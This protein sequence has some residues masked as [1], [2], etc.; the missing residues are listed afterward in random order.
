[1]LTGLSGQSAACRPDEAPLPTFGALLSAVESAQCSSRHLRETAIAQEQ[2]LQRLRDNLQRVAG[3]G[4]IPH[5]P[6][7]DKQQPTAPTSTL[8]AAACLNGSPLDSCCQPPVHRD[9]GEPALPQKELRDPGEP[10]LLQK[11]H[12]AARVALTELDSAPSASHFGK[13]PEDAAM[14]MAPGASMTSMEFLQSQAEDGSARPSM[15]SNGSAD[16]EDKS[17]QLSMLENLQAMQKVQSRVS[18]C[19]SISSVA[20]DAPTLRAAWTQKKG[21]YKQKQ[22]TLRRSWSTQSGVASVWGQYR[23]KDLANGKE[24]F[25][26]LRRCILMPAGPVKLSWDLLCFIVI[27]WDVVMLPLNAFESTAWQMMFFVSV[28]TAVFWT[29]DM[30][31]SFCS[32]FHREDGMVETDPRQ[33]AWRYLRTWF[34]LDVCVLTLDWLLVF[35]DNA[36]DE[37]TSAGRVNKFVRVFRITKALRFV[38]L[39]RIVKLATYYEEVCEVVF[40]A[41]LV[42]CFSIA[43]LILILALVV[44]YIACAWYTVGMSRHGKEESWITRWV[45]R[46][47]SDLYLYTISFHW[48]MAQFLPAPSPDHPLNFHERVFTIGVLFTGFVVFSSTMGSVTALITTSRKQAYQK[49]VEGHTIRRF[50]VDNS[51]SHVLASRIMHSINQISANRK[52]MVV[53]SDL[54]KLKGIPAVLRMDLHYHMHM[55]QLAACPFFDTF[56]AHSPALREICDCAVFENMYMADDMP[57]L[58]RAPGTAMRFVK[59]GNLDYFHGQAQEQSFF[60]SNATPIRAKDYLSEVALWVAWEHKGYVVATC[61]SIVIR[62]DVDPFVQVIQKHTRAFWHCAAYAD[63]LVRH[64]EDTV[65]SNLPI[66]DTFRAFTARGEVLD[67][68]LAFHDGGSVAA[69]T[70]AH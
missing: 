32:G 24:D 55:Q 65:R 36:T 54:P 25:G 3:A 60:G 5:A 16:A 15:V 43:R 14:A 63:V 66:D 4:C 30:A 2:E 41:W 53:E 20:M 26:L 1:M 6:L 10:V 47:A 64:M 29:V 42:T 51:V 22:A 70:D 9:P 8:Q 11:A 45:N 59:S 68:L 49:M 38:R 40:S 37:A 39:A 18:V 23:K 34:G 69:S 50:F 48:T 56:D 19:S 7:Q 67:E 52:A 61:T 58:Y 33:T 62:V 31:I 27:S 21:P 28:V 35:V 17:S 13:P 12:E 44:H 46:Q 57:F